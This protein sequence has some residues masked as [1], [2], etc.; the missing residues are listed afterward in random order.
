MYICPKCNFTTENPA[1]FCMKCGSALVE[2]VPEPQPVEPTYYQPAPEQTYY[3]PPYQAPRQPSRALGIVG[4][5]L[6]IVGLGLTAIGG[7]ASLVYLVEEMMDEL[8]VSGFTYFFLAFPLSLVGM[9]LC[10]KSL[11]AGST[12]KKCV[13]GKLLGIPGIIVAGANLSLICL[14]YTLYF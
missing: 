14:L 11:N 9:I 4:M 12:D 10:N 8:L 2:S 13:V 6:S 5:V 3:Q 7:L 1:N